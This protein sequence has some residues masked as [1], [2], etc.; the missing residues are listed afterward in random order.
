MGEPPLRRNERELERIQTGV[1]VGGA[2]PWRRGPPPPEGALRG[3]GPSAPRLRRSWPRRFPLAPPGC[4]GSTGLPLRP[5]GAAS[6]GQSLWQG[7]LTHQPPPRRTQARPPGEVK[8]SAYGNK[9][10]CI[11]RSVSAKAGKRGEQRAS[12]CGRKAHCFPRHL[13]AFGH[14]TLLS[15]VSFLGFCFSPGQPASPRSP[16]QKGVGKGQRPGTGQ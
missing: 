7:A 12:T 9:Y 2:L 8:V 1:E 11:E 16:L 13:A 5:L 3:P 6:R 15:A 14:P 4:R 10:T